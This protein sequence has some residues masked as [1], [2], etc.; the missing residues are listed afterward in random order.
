[1]EQ[2]DGSKLLQACPLE[3]LHTVATANRLFYKSLYLVQPKGWFI[4]GVVFV[5]EVLS[6]M[7]Q[8]SA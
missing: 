2:S 3:E 8:Y 6:D 1:M 7:M 4:S 5:K